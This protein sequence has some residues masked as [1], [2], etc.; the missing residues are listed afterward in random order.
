MRGLQIIS[1]LADEPGKSPDEIATALQ[2]DYTTVNA[3]LHRLRQLRLVE[4]AGER[5]SKTGRPAVLWRLHS[6]L[7]EQR[8]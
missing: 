2:A 5:P 3:N 1:L 8:A 7:R 4:K 6:R